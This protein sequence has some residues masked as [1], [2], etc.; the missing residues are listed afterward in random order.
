VLIGLL[1]VLA[2][3]LVADDVGEHLADR[4]RQRFV[5]IGLMDAMAGSRELRQAINDLN[6]RL[7][8]ARG[9]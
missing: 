9:E 3:A 2:G 6:Q 1:A 8:Y 5:R 4:L 7:R